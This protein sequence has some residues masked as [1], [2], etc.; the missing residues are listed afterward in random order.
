MSIVFDY[1]YNQ[2]KLSDRTLFMFTIGYYEQNRFFSYNFPKS[3]LDYLLE[4]NQLHET[5][6]IIPLYSLYGELIGYSVRYFNTNYKFKHY[7]ERE[8]A[9]FGLNIAW[10]SIL[11]CN[12]VIVVEGPFDLMVLYQ[13]ETKNVV[14]ASGNSLTFNNLCLLRRFTSKAYIIFDG[15]EGGVTGSKKLKEKFEQV[16]INALCIY[17]PKGYDPDS[18]VNEKGIKNLINLIKGDNLC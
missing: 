17:L 15:D 2:K 6:I 18:Y 4:S 5:Q 8:N 13:N 10:K 11:E 7:Y 1:L 12:E 14:C 16:G 3:L 9:I